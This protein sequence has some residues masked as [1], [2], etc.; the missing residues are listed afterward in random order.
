[1]GNFMAGVTGQINYLRVA[2]TVISQ[3][4]LTQITLMLAF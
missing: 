1:M 3:Q 4:S 2:L